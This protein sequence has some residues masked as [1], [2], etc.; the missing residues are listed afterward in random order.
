MVT[1]RANS[2]LFGFNGSDQVE[3]DRS[4]R[5]PQTHEWHYSCAAYCLQPSFHET[6]HP[7][8]SQCRL[9][10]C[11]PEGC[12]LLGPVLHLHAR[13]VFCSD[14][15]LILGDGDPRW[16]EVGFIDCCK[17]KALVRIQALL[18]QLF[19]RGRREKGNRFDFILVFQ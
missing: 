3:F 4:A 18:F 5:K 14:Q 7:I 8:W 6:F 13:I 2:S 15:V 11:S 9:Q 19:R 10:H 12:H 1:K 16:K 17:E